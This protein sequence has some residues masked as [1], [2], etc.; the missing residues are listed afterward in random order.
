MKYLSLLAL[1]LAGAALTTQS[2]VNSQLRGALHGV[3]WA[4]LASYV[5]GT[6]AAG[7]ALVA[8]RAPLPGLAAV[9]GVKWYQ[10][11]G[12]AL[13]MV[14]LAA[15]TFALPRVGAASAFALVVS[16][17]LL[18]ALL[19]DQLGLLSLARSSLTPTKLV[20]VL[21]LAGGAYLLNRR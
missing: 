11:T 14:Y 1:V 8:S 18:T 2:A 6:L 4:V 10:W 21:L 17:Q 5:V 20:G 16:G 13:G 3:L 19:Y 15:I 12:G 9:S 7:A